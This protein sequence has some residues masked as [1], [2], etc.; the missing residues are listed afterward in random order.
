MLDDLSGREFEAWCKVVF[1]RYYDCPVSDQPHVAD[2]GRDLI[3]HDPDGDIVVECK[4]SPDDSVGRPDV[5]KLH[6]AIQTA[7]TDRGMVAT[8]GRIASTIP[9]YIKDLD[10]EIDL[11]DGSRL[12]YMAETVGLGEDAELGDALARAVR[13]T[14]D[15]AFPEAFRERVYRAP[16]YVAGDGYESDIEIDRET[17]Y[18]GYYVASYEAQGSRE[19]AVGTRR[20][21]WSG[22]IRCQK[23]GNA[24]GRGSPPGEQLDVESVE[25]LGDVLE[26]V[27]GPTEPPTLQP[28][29][30]EDRMQ[31]YLSSSLARSI[32]YTGR[33]NVTYTKDITP[34]RSDVR[35]RGIRLVYVPVQ[36]IRVR[37]GDTEHRAQLSERDDRF[38]VKGEAFGV[39]CICRR[40]L[41]AEDQVLCAVCL[42][43]A[44]ERS[45][46]TP[47]SHRCQ[48][49][50]ATIC[51]D[52]AQRD[53]RGVV[54][55]RCADEE[56]EPART[57]WLPHVG[58]G[59]GVPAGL[60]AIAWVVPGNQVLLVLLAAI[61]SWWPAW[62]V[63]REGDGSVPWVEY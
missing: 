30:A 15:E 41:S 21:R 42:R 12:A 25:P 63:L 48:D 1:E 22:K 37:S 18:E 53:E 32:T 17:R 23:D 54:C 8:T 20:A 46:L 45:F 51:H 58:I 6:S 60:G 27:E 19:T 7:Q 39:C 31:E 4:H 9:D 38:R 2:E 3:I 26:D 28:H 33:N 43:A 16:R 34:N 5:Q 24:L 59:V 29:D 47:D 13:T 11:V 14:P 49:C 57:R 40:G 50:G 61:A 62:R 36:R 35:L 10:T 56:A 55:T 52:H 44:H